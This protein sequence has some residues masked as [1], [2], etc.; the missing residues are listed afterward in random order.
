[1]KFMNKILCHFVSHIGLYFMVFAFLIVGGFSIKWLHD[2]WDDNPE[3]HHP[4]LIVLKTSEDNMER[5]SVVQFEGHLWVE[6]SSA[7]GIGIAHSPDCPCQK[8]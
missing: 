2:N 1:M 6:C 3:A 8:K 7:T 5:Y 4:K